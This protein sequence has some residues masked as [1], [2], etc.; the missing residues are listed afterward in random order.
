MAF[1]PFFA[2]TERSKSK[3]V[4]S[5]HTCYTLLETYLIVII[6]KTVKILIK[7]GFWKLSGTKNAIKSLKLAQIW[8]F[9]HFLRF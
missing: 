8:L 6:P 7:S 4:K 1:Q 3:R 2:F 5:P 9:R